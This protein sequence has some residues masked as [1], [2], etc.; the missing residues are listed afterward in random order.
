MI[1]VGFRICFNLS[2]SL[3][4]VQFVTR[5]SQSRIQRLCPQDVIRCG[6]KTALHPL[7]HL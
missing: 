6:W 1:F 4:L 3:L 5:L 2:I 7:F